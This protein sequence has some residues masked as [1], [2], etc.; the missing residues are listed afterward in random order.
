LSTRSLSIFIRCFV[1]E[2][3]TELKLFSI[4][5]ILY[6]LSIG[7]WF[8]SND[9]NC[10]YLADAF[11]KGRFDVTDLPPIPIDLALYR[12]RWYSPFP[13]L[14]SLLVAPLVYV[15][16]L[17]YNVRFV[18]VLFG[19]INVV[20]AWR[21]LEKIKMR[22]E[23]QRWLILL[24]SFGSI[25]WFYSTTLFNHTYSVFFLLAA[26]NETLSR[27]R[28]LLI[29]FYLGCAGLCRYPTLLAASFF[30]LCLRREQLKKDVSLFFLGLAIPLLFL[31]YYNYARFGSPLETGYQY[32]INVVRTPK[33]FGIFDPR[34]I[35]SNLYTIL[36]EPMSL[37]TRFPYVIPRTSGLALTF[38][39]P[40][41]VL[42]LKARSRDP[43]IVG[44]WCSILLISTLLMCYFSNGADQFGYRYG[45]D[46]FPFL[47][48]LTSQAVHN[49]LNAL[50]K[51]LI[52]VGVAVN[53]WGILFFN[54]INL[55]I[56]SYFID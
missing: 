47:F 41:S 36:L 23:E 48:L 37:T 17:S 7:N 10:I 27:N 50:V 29:G 28:P 12:G 49:S 11:L 8:T 5:F 38:T 21:L 33:P 24:F 30:L 44:S 45:L 14:P 43:R 54:G 25:H 42:A 6:S 26:M 13:P 16:G 40:A 56:L 39:T 51:L 15:L 3:K 2:H 52:V 22:K 46:F 1:K 53:F 4:T 20:L 55:S 9:M 19:S 31:F 32:E 34:Y 35:P 18:T